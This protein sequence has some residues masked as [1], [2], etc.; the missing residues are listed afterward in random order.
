MPKNNLKSMIHLIKRSF[1]YHNLFFIITTRM[2]DKSGISVSL[3]YPI[4]R[5]I[6]LREIKLVKHV[7]DL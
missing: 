4:D 2:I 1:D 3:F 7:H 5:V 6:K